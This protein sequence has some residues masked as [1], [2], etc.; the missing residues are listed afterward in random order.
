MGNKTALNFLSSAAGARPSI[1]LTHKP[2][3]LV[4]TLGFIADVQSMSIFM[5]VFALKQ[6]ALVAPGCATTLGL[7]ILASLPSLAFRYA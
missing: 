1:N 7:D 4:L 5:R 2:G 3:L 6:A